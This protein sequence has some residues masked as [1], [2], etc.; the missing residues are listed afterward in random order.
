MF[1]RTNKAWKALALVLALCMLSSTVAFA[2]D[3]ATIENLAVSYAESDNLVTVTGKFSD[4]S[5]GNDVTILAVRSAVAANSDGTGGIAMDKVVGGSDATGEK[6]DGTEV[7]STSTLQDQVVYIDQEASNE[8]TGAFEFKFIPRTAVSGGTITVFVGGE[9]VDTVKSFSIPAPMKAPDV[10]AP[11]AW[12]EGETTLVM[13]I[14]KAGSTTEAFGNA[15][16]VEKWGNAI[17]KVEIK[18]TADGDYVE[19]TNYEV[20]KGVDAD[21]SA[22]PPVEAVAPTFELSGFAE[23]GAALYGV[24]IT[25]TNNDYSVEEWSDSIAQ[26]KKDAG[27][28]STDKT[29]YVVGEPITFAGTGEDEV[30]NATIPAKVYAKASET[31]L[32]A[33]QIGDDVAAT[34]ATLSNPATMLEE[35]YWATVKADYYKPSNVVSYTVKAPALVKAEAVT[36]ADVKV[37]Y[38]GTPDDDETTTTIMGTENVTTPLTGENIDLYGAAVVALPPAPEGFSYTWT[39]TQ[40]EGQEAELPTDLTGASITLDRPNYDATNA[41]AKSYTY[42]LTLAVKDLASEHDTWKVAE[43]PFTLSATRVGMKGVPVTINPVLPGLNTGNDLTP[44]Q[45][46]KNIAI[47]QKAT[48]TLVGTGG[49]YSLTVQ[50][51]GTIKAEGVTAGTYN[52]TVT[53]PGFVTKTVEFTINDDGSTTGTFP[54]MIFGDNTGG[55]NGAG[56]GAVEYADYMDLYYVYGQSYSDD[57]LLRFDSDANG[58][59]EYSDYMDLYYNYG[60]PNI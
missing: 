1:K 33:D 14:T 51:D 49:S 19:T 38:S 23:T 43:M 5:A 60:Y 8:T 55:E 13:S 34:T 52:L 28:L 9:N 17:S 21:A 6:L 42:T 53:R 31:A 10:N 30:W 7:W 48:Y 15:A 24:K 45:V 44:E 35:T 36:N 41:T 56:D 27:T 12:Y 39:I 20:N 46:E 37:V 54:E 29:E 57:S 22:E 3:T 32:T 11:A 40:P 18:T 58:I 47:A 4:G 25:T 59:I 26:K 50:N 16:A 2:V